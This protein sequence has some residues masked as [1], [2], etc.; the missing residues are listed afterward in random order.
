MP[1]EVLKGQSPYEVF[2]KAKP[3]HE[4]LRTIGCMCYATNLVKHDKLSSRADA[5]VMMG[6]PANQKRYILYNLRYILYNLRHKKFTVSRDVIFKENIFPFKDLKTTHEPFFMDQPLTDYDIE[7]RVA[8][9]IDKDQSTLDG[10]TQSSLELN[11]AL[12]P[13]SDHESYQQELNI[14]ANDEI[15]ENESTRKAD[16]GRHSNT[17]SNTS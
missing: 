13:T 11:E 10:D 5:C 8:P 16:L 4:H 17:T 6:Y 14:D 2:H 9:V 1:T 7:T 3:Q 12:V 15:K